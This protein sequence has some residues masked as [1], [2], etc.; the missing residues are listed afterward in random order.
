MDE[1]EPV[2]VD[3]ARKNRSTIASVSQGAAMHPATAAVLF[4]AVRVQVIDRGQA[5]RD[6]DPDAE[7]GPAQTANGSPTG[8][9][10]TH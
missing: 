5:E 4:S 8:C 3:G 10:S 6:L 1:A 2:G 9:E 7:P